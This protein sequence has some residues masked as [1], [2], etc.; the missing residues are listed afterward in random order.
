MRIYKRLYLGD[1]VAECR[2]ELVAKLTAHTPDDA[3]FVITLPPDETGNLLEIYEYK[4][5]LEGRPFS[6]KL[7]SG[8]ELSD[9]HVVGVSSGKAEAIEVVRD[10]VDEISS[11]TGSLQVRDFFLTDPENF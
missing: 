9:I 7:L 6:G 3:L 8:M 5:L 4:K 2:D 11:K 10:I 1:S